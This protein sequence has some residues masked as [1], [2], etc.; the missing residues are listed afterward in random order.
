[1]LEAFQTSWIGFY[2]GY[3][4]K[5]SENGECVTFYNPKTKERVQSESRFSIS[6]YT[7]DNNT[8]LYLAP[9]SFWDTVKVENQENR[10]S[11]ESLS[12]IQHGMKVVGYPYTKSPY[13]KAPYFVA[14]KTNHSVQPN[15]LIFKNFLIPNSFGLILCVLNYD[16]NLDKFVT[17][18]NTDILLPY[19][20]SSS[21]TSV[22]EFTIVDANQ[23]M[24][25]FKDDSQIFVSLKVL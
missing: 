12:N 13:Y 22:L 11:V 3:Q 19:N 8:K 4:G 18:I 6:F 10:Y 7:T 5:L 17:T 20:N 9:K 2:Y 1:V 25:Q 24:V 15:Y 14:F 23:K 21:L 16:D